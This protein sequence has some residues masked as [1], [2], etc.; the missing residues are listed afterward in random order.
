M[1]VSRDDP[2]KVTLQKVILIRILEVL[3][4]AFREKWGEGT[5]NRI[6]MVGRRVVGTLI[7]TYGA[8]G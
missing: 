5:I 1:S 4:E 6:I 3:E 2:Q 8:L 7:S